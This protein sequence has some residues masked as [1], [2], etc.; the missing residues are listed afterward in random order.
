MLRA[1]G[2]TRSSRVWAANM[3]R[4]QRAA[5]RE[6]HV[7]CRHTICAVVSGVEGGDTRSVGCFLLLRGGTRRGLTWHERKRMSLSPHS[8]VVCESSVCRVRILL[9]AA[10]HTV[11]CGVG[12]VNERH[13]AR[14]D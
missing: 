13:G 10:L 1:R 4:A 9:L 3:G 14:W 8:A 5:E 12:G 7:R 2:H 6:R 11:V